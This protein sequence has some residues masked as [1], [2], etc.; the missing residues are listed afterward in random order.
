MLRDQKARSIRLL[1]GKWQSCWGMTPQMQDKELYQHILG[2]MSSSSQASA[3]GLLRQ[4]STCHGQ[5]LS[6]NKT[7]QAY[8]RTIE[9]RDGAYGKPPFWLR[10]QH[11]QEMHCSTGRS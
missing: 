10:E 4:T 5:Y 9:Q 1:S 8:W 2:L 6:T 3:C 7:S 11:D